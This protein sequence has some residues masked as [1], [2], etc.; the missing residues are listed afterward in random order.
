MVPS[1]K[2]LEYCFKSGSL[3]ANHGLIG[4]GGVLEC[5]EFFVVHIGGSEYLSLTR[6][7][8]QRWHPIRTANGLL[9]LT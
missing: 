9:K 4:Q 7:P 1:G 5:N 2:S 8:Y 3:A 6:W